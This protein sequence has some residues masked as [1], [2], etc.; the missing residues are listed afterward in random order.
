L[1]QVG[2]FAQWRTSFWAF[3][4]IAILLLLPLALLLE[5][6]RGMAETMRA[7]PRR[8]RIDYSD[9]VHEYNDDDAADRA[10]E[11]DRFIERSMSEFGGST[12]PSSSSI[13]EEKETGSAWT[14]GFTLQFLA[15]KSPSYGWYGNVC[16]S[17][18]HHGCSTDWLIGW[19]AH[20]AFGSRAWCAGWQAIL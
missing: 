14:L 13:Y 20:V 4:G 2:E 9:T 8:A 12:S 3:G 16:A 17:K 7:D 18:A 11:G 15:L 19:L 10:T 1:R 5:P 6:K